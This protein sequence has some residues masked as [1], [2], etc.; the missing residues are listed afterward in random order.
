MITKWLEV[1]PDIPVN[2]LTVEIVINEFLEIIVRFG[3]LKTITLD[4]AKCFTGF[5]FQLYCK[6]LGIRH[7]SV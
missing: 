5:E 6:N 2:N 3:F 1:F 4:G 7:M